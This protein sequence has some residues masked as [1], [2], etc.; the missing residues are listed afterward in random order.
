MRPLKC[1][2]WICKIRPQKDTFLGRGFLK[3]WTKQQQHVLTSRFHVWFSRIQVAIK[4]QRKVKTLLETDK[5][6]STYTERQKKEHKPLISPFACE[7]P[8]VK[9]LHSV[10]AILK[11][12][13]SQSACVL[14]SLLMIHGGA[15]SAWK[16]WKC[17]LTL[18][19]IRYR[20]CPNGQLI[21]V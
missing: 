9:K 21:T 4:T 12:H 20:F 17:R 8:Y 1:K 19:Q 10:A 2:H 3:N 14:S 7:T 5:T 6:I 13:V 11:Y 16:S 18:V 15:H